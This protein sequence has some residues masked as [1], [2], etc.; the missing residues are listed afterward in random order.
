MAVMT[1]RAT[2]ALKQM[3]SGYDV[4]GNI[5]QALPPNGGRPALRVCKD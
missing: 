3:A 5:C 1:S 2:S 4:A